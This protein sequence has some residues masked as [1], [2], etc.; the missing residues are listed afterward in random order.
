MHNVNPGLKSLFQKIV[1]V[2]SDNQSMLAALHIKNGVHAVGLDAAYISTIEKENKDAKILAKRLADDVKT[3]RMEN[4]Q[5]RADIR[6]LGSLDRAEANLLN[7]VQSQLNDLKDNF[8][9]VKIDKALTNITQ[10]LD[11]M[12]TVQFNTDSKQDSAIGSVDLL[13][14]QLQADSLEQ[15]SQINSLKENMRISVLS[16]TDKKDHDFL[17]NEVVRL[18]R[19]L[20]RRVQAVASSTNHHTDEMERCNIKLDL[21]QST[22]ESIMKAKADQAS[23]TKLAK[24]RRDAHVRA[25][26]QIE[27][28]VNSIQSV[29]EASSILEKVQNEQA[30]LNDHMRMT[31]W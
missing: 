2:I 4:V 3:L 8:D 16:K 30:E 1:T 11:N 22:V 20:E 14:K 7:K 17:S 9:T 23:L 31:A 18:T 5:L 25:Q 19:A 26:M 10:R 13:V 24:E 6:M 27:E 29:K 15:D 21:V 28:L 12:E